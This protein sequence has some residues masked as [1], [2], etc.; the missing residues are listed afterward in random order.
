MHKN[1][2]NKKK[3]FAPI[4]VYSMLCMIICACQY[5]ILQND[6]ESEF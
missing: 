3:E 1:I 6:F 2:Y 4:G 5:N